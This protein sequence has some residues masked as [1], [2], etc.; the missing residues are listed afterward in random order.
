VHCAIRLPHAGNLGIHVPAAVV[1]IEHLRKVLSIDCIRTWLRPIHYLKRVRLH[2]RL[3]NKCL[4]IYK[5]TCC[6]T[7]FAT[8]FA[9]TLWQSSFRDVN[10]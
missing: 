5:V 7:I 2:E 1:F 10:S 4:A 9:T 6:S 8:G 3:S